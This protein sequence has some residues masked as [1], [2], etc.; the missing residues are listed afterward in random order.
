MHVVRVVYGIM[1]N[2]TCART[3][4]NI[5]FKICSTNALKIWTCT[6]VKRVKMMEIDER[7]G[8]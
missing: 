4:E 5:F 7:V 8:C 1:H 2:L 3:V 6:Y